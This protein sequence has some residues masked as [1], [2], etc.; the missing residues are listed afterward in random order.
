[1][2]PFAGY[3]MPVNYADGI[4]RE[5]LHT[6]SAAGLFDVS[7]MGQIRV[8]G[9]QIAEK[10]ET[11]LPVDLL[12]LKPWRQKYALFLNEDGGVLDDLMVIHLGAEFMLV[13][14][15]AC[16]HNDLAYLQ[17]HLGTEL[18]FSLLEDRALVA[19]QGPK[20]AAVV[21]SEAGE[22]ID[23]STMKFMHAAELSLNGYSCLVTRSGYTGEDGFEISI[24]A[25]Q[26]EAFCRQLLRHED[27]KPVG[28]GARD[29]LRL[30]A[31][32]CLYGQDL[33]PERTPIEANIAWAISP[34]RRSTGERAGGFPGAQH[35]FE[36]QQSG[37]AQK[38]VALL[39]EGRAPVRAGTKLF[40]SNQKPVG[41]VTSGGFSPS[42]GKPVSLG[43]V[44]TKFSDTGTALLAEVRGKQLPVNIVSL[45]FVKHSY[46]R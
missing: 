29:S 26:A 16:K 24:A 28:L 31:G 13:V 6:R 36:Q 38:L 4:I 15:A 1:M 7:H 45:P 27:V 42:L 43:Y 8:Q 35:L 33:T 18:D 3:E 37:T 41:K 32:L 23:L 34:A 20:A 21:Q 44:S 30:E 39:P 11:V 40:D 5:H 2:V 17:S 14:N 25:K 46:Y 10:L 12:S 19:L 9:E 22:D